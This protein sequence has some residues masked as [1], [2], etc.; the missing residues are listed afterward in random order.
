MRI[1]KKDT[2]LAKLLKLMKSEMKLEMKLEMKR[3]LLAKQ[4]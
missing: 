3:N 1:S 2:T 4:R